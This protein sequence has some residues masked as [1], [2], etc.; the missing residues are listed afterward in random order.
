M[1]SST[2]LDSDRSG[3]G[4]GTKL[5]TAVIRVASDQHCRRVYL[6]TTNDNTPALR[7][8]QRFGMTLS[9]LHINA[10]EV[11]RK[12]NLRSLSPAWMIFLSAMKSSWNI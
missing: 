9:G 6:I 3:L 7:F 11:S 8:Y 2:T 10:I 12:V 1:I 4:I 5:L